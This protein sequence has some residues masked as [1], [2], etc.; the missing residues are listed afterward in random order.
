MEEGER[1]GRG[2][3][4]GRSDSDACHSVTL[5]CA[6]S[7]VVGGGPVRLTSSSEVSVII[8]ADGALAT[9]A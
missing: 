9:V 4:G 8:L 1:D 5:T 3:G 6:R 2:G 7:L